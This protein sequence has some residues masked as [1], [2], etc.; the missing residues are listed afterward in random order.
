M[1]HL[2]LDASVLLARTGGSCQFSAG[3]WV[4]VQGGVW[5]FLVLR[6]RGPDEGFRP[7]RLRVWHQAFVLACDS[8]LTPLRL[9]V[10]LCV[11][12][13]DTQSFQSRGLLMKG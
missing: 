10:V 8:L 7:W 6:K 4:V 1:P 2:H 5:G 13:C 3:G 11:D 9:T 12:G